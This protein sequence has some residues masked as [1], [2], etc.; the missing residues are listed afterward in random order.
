MVW[1][2]LRVEDLVTRVAFAIRHR[3]RLSKVPRPFP[4]LHPVWFS[5]RDMDAANEVARR[6]KCEGVI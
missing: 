6:L 3:E 1:M 5:T 4:P 2:P